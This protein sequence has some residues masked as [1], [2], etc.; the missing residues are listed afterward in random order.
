MGVAPK[1]LDTCR[2]LDEDPD[3]AEALP[4]G[5]RERAADELVTPCMSF[6]TGPWSLP[7]LDPPGVGLIVLKG[8]LLRHVAIDGRLGLELARRVG[9][10][11]AVAGRRRT[12]DL[13]RGRV[14]RAQRSQA[15][16]ARR[17]LRE[18][19]RALSGTGEQAARARDAP[20]SHYVTTLAM[21]AGLG[22]TT[23]CG[24]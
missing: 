14:V 1:P 9:P 3:L 8:V 24:C 23:G 7:Q 10:G 17:A 4:P 11:P 16:L 6:P 5:R 21:Y 12:D 20:S 2:L 22:S 19:A 15:R 13:A 18:R